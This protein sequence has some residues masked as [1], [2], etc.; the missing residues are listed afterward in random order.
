MATCHPQLQGWVGN[1][2]LLLVLN[3]VDMVSDA[4]QAAW[5]AHF[6]QRQQPT[7]WTDAK[8]GTGVRKVTAL[9]WRMLAKVLCCHYKGQQC[10]NPDSMQRFM[11]LGRHQ[12]VAKAAVAAGAGINEAR[13][14]RGLRPRPLKAAVVSRVPMSSITSVF[15]S[16]QHRKKLSWAME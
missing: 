16:V 11:V 8:L 9:S 10:H 3:R 6:R 13:H 15:T 5:A 2:P 12:Q 7:Y 14:R 4:D 1:K